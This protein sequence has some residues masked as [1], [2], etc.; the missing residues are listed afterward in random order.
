M[1]KPNRP[2]AKARNTSALAGIDKHITGTV[3]IG[4]V[5]YTPA[6]LKQVLIDQ[7]T[8]IDAADALHKQW[9]DQVLVTKE[10]DLKGTPPTTP[11]A[12]I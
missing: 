10:A 9:Q 1:P 6:T 12:P 7:S 2:S 3:T 11:C 8:A 5:T 4:G